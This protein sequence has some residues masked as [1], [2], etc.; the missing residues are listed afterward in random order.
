MTGV[1]LHSQVLDVGLIN[2]CP[3]IW[4]TSSPDHKKVH[5]HTHHLSLHIG[6]P[7]CSGGAARLSSHLAEARLL[8]P[9]RVPA[10][11]RA[12]VASCNNA[13]RVRANQTTRPVCPR[14]SAV[15]QTDRA[16]AK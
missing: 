13:R 7:L 16:P 2:S 10:A 12:P 5:H 1:Y 8:C 6:Q 9:P 14:Q 15:S 4:V 3:T 11:S